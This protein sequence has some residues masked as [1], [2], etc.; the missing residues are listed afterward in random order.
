MGKCHLYS[1]P[2]SD[3][4]MRSVHCLYLCETAERVAGWHRVSG[5]PDGDSSDGVFRGRYGM[6]NLITLS[7][8]GR[9]GRSCGL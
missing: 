7:R 1:V 5:D 4:T 2:N 6:Q 3:V 8:S 9:N